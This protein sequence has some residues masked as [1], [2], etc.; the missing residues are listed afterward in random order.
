MERRDV[1]EDIILL[2]HHQS[3]KRPHMT[4]WER[5]AQFSPFAALKGYEEM[6]E[7]SE[8]APQRQ[9]EFPDE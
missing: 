6:L 1:Y 9:E 3:K 5:A 8:D 4:A 7:Q 2:P